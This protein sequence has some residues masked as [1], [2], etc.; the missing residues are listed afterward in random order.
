MDKP[1]NNVSEPL[2]E[3]RSCREHG[4]FR[5]RGR[6]IAS[7]WLVLTLVAL[8]AFIAMVIDVGWVV[9]VGHQLSAAADAS[10]LAGTMEV[11][12]DQDDARAEAVAYASVNLAAGTSVTVDANNANIMTGDVII[13]YFDRPSRTFTNSPPGHL[14]PNAVRVN[15]RR[16]T[17]SPD[18]PIEPLF[19]PI[20][21]NGNGWNVQRYAIAMIYGDVGAGVIALNETDPLSFDARG[22]SASFQ[23]RNGTVVV[24]STSS[25]AAGY[26]GNPYIEAEEFRVVGDA[27]GGFEDILTGQLYTDAEPVPDPLAALPE[28]NA[29]TVNHGN[30]KIKNKDNITLQPG[31]YGNFDMTGGNVTLE[32]GLYYITGEFKFNGGTIDGTAGVMFFI[33]PGG[34]MDA[35][36]NGTLQLTGMTPITYPNGPTVPAAVAD[37]KVP[38]FQSR[39]N[40]TQAE[41]NGN[42]DWLIEGTIYTHSAL[43]LLRGTPGTFANGL[44]ADQIAQRGNNDLI[45]DYEDQF[46]VLPRKVFLV[47]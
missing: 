44:I 42:G 10:S 31:R 6:G 36:G 28:P 1:T 35:A 25:T 30:V 18:G 47:K 16:T 12:R 46:G 38:I 37:I 24:N 11:R 19:V 34:N 9:L 27:E 20:G 41:I 45:I 29:P 33:A 17:G 2:R 21:G 14:G 3:L 7:I 43:L 4:Q 13:G 23:V 8:V 5:G 40:T 22:S 15:A 39:S 32:A 26:S